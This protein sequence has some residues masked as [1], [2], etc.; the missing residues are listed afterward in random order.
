MAASGRALTGLGG[1]ARPPS[2]E[3]RAA[4]GRRRHRRLQR[5]FATAYERELQ[6]WVD[7]EPA[8]TDPWDGCAAAV[9]C[10]AAVESLRSGYT[11]DL[12]LERALLTR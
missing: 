5:R 1:V 9:V 6:S 2:G 7:G 8:G 10:E 12:R 3:R 4:R 11:V